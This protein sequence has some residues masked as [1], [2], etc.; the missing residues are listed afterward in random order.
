[1]RWREIN[2]KIKWKKMPITNV[3]WKEH[4]YVSEIIPIKIIHTNPWGRKRKI[5]TPSFRFSKFRIDMV[6]GIIYGTEIEGEMKSHDRKAICELIG[7]EDISMLKKF[8]ILA[9]KKDYN[10][11]GNMMKRST[12]MNIFVEGFLLP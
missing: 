1:M 3:P 5:V 12:I 2:E 8:V 9:L 7:T 11:L 10:A 4:C 6:P